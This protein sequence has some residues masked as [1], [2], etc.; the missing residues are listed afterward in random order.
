MGAIPN[1]LPGFQDVEDDALLEVRAGDGTCR[2]PEAWL[3]LTGM[4]EAI[5]HGELSA[6][7]VIGENPA[8]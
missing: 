4:F 5:E 6:L 8:Q 1:K 3:H 2:Y 7:Y